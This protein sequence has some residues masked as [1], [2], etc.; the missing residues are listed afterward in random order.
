[1][2]DYPDLVLQFCCDVCGE[3]FADLDCCADKR[4]PQLVVNKLEKTG[5]CY[6]CDN[7][8]FGDYFFYRSD[9][10]IICE[11]CYGGWD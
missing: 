8:I 10:E 1:M 6:E 2:T 9:D 3:F 5:V 7:D 4:K 11:D